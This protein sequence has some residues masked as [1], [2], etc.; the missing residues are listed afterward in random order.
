MLLNSTRTSGNLKLAGKLFHRFTMAAAAVLVILSLVNFRISSDHD[1]FQLSFS[2]L[3]QDL[4]TG[5]LNQALTNLPYDPEQIKLMAELTEMSNQKQ[6]E[7]IAVLLGEFYQ[8]VEMKRMADLKIISQTLET[9]RNDADRKIESTNDV[10]DG[11]IQFT[12]RLAEK[13]VRIKE[14]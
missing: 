4:K 2:L 1:G 13:E 10:L 3:G 12:G 7:D 6:K 14:R 5:D 8:A 9:F 11:L